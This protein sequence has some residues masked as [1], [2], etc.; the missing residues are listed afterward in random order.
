MHV[1]DPAQFS[2]FSKWEFHHFLLSIFHHVRVSGEEEE[3][4]SIFSASVLSNPPWS[5]CNERH[6]VLAR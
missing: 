3:L 5:F 2:A 4:R 6:I 1:P